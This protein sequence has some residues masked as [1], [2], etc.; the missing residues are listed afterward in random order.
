VSS[1]RFYLAAYFLIFCSI[2]FT[3]S[4]PLVSG[5]PVVQSIAQGDQAY[6]QRFDI[7]ADEPMGFLKAYK[8]YIER[9]IGYYALS[10]QDPSSLSI[11]S[12]AYVYNRLAQLNYELAKVLILEAGGRRKAFLELGGQSRSRA[13]M[14][15][16][17]KVLSIRISTDRTQRPFYNALAKCERSR[18]RG[19]S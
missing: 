16:A 15:G 14:A 2:L 17:G 8:P 12:Q 18:Y 4:F 13:S 6:N 7:E 5:N 9:A 11:Q 19:T 3:L 10:I 1:R